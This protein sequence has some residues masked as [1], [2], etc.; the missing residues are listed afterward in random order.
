M[1]R[2][3]AVLA[4][5]GWPA[6]RATATVTLAFDDRHRRRILMKDDAGGEFLLDLAEARVLND[7]D[8]LE[9]DGGQGLVRVVAAPEAVL[10]VECRSPAE[11]ARLAWHIG[12][13]HTAVQVLDDN[14][15][16]IRD[17][18]ILKDMLEGLGA[19]VIRRQAPF[20]PEPGAYAKSQTGSHDD[21]HGHDHGHANG[22]RHAH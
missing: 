7:G 2:A 18:H 3:V 19:T 20:Q 13:R 10:D 1:R 15:L 12:N 22:H 9:L 8:G 11:T 4:K 17:D 16:R 6:E 14:R 21:N 5:G